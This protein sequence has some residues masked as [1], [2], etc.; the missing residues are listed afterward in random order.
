ETQTRAHGVYGELG[1]EPLDWWAELDIDLRNEPS[2][3]ASA[4][5]D[6]S[7]VT[8]FDVASSPLVNPRLADQTGAKSGAWIP[9][10]AEGKVPGVLAVA[11][12]DEKR[13]CAADEMALLTAFVADGGLA[14]ARLRSGEALSAALAEHER[15]LAEASTEHARQGRIQLGF[16]KVA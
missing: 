13:A 2:G 14:L 4:V 6:R 8:V 12:T 15:R 9:M 7:P 1:G 3:I 16:S 10:A 5:F 11:A